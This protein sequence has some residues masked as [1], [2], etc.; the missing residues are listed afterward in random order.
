MHSFAMALGRR[1]KRGL[2]LFDVILAVGILGILI[3]GGV[4]LLQAVNERIARNGTLSLVNQIRSE[5]SRIYAGRPHMNNLVIEGLWN[6]GS[7]PDDTYRGT[8]TGKITTAAEA[9]KLKHPYDGMVKAWG[10][11]GSKQFIIGLADLD[12]SACSDILGPWSGKSRSRSGILAAGVAKNSGIAVGN[13]TSTGLVAGN[14]T[15]KNSPFTAADVDGWCEE[16][17]KEND[18]Y[19]AFQG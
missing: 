4:L 13:V 16:G 12:D 5:V 9:D 3:A 19:I 17:D 11:A 14:I 6:R 10:V 18:I 8:G 15:S 1:Q 2:A 7:L